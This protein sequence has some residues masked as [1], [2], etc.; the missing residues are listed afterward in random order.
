MIEQ[1]YTILSN[2]PIALDTYRMICSG[3][4]TVFTAPGQFV[5]VKIDPLYLRRPF[6]VCDWSIQHGTV[7]LVYKCVGTGTDR[8]REM[9]A[10]TILNVLSPLGNGFDTSKGGQNPLVIGG[11]VGTPPLLGLCKQLVR[12][13]KKPQ[14]ILGFNTKDDVF[15]E[16]EFEEIGLK[17]IIATMDGSYGLRGMVTDAC[18]NVQGEYFFACGPLKM[19]QAICCSL[20][21]EGQV[22]LEERMGCGFGAC[23]GCS[24][25]TKEGPQR[26]CK[27]GPVFERKVLD[28]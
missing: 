20:P 10:G 5:N 11:G 24:I 17:P 6:S 26:V 22:S 4:A 23:M 9:T 8:M 25:M 7:T 16:K 18:I 19:L 1:Q 27:E 2:E 14:V 3:D 12:E 21:S 13:G 15:F 28:W